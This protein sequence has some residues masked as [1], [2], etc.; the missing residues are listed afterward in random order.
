MYV[1]W[2]LTEETLTRHRAAQVPVRADG[3]S[4]YPEEACQAPHTSNKESAMKL[5]RFLVIGLVAV[6][7][8]SCASGTTAPASV[9]VSGKWQGT[10]AY[11]QATLGSGQIVMTVTQ[12]G[13]KA[14]G[15]MTVT[16]TPIDRSGA[17]TLLVSGNDVYMVYPTGITG[18]LVVSGDEMK[19]QIDGV[20]PGNVTLRRQ[21]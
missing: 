7:L 17:V 21:K 14:M 19:G 15:N 4:S 8:S 3:A 20:N 5:G 6:G 1:I 2:A 13:S 16:G 11:Q 9:D 12:P 18:Y 10:W